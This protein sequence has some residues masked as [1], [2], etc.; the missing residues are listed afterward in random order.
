MMKKI[1]IFVLLA[2]VL[3]LAPAHMLMAK[4][5]DLQAIKKAVKKNPNIDPD[6]EVKWFKI[7][8]T[9]TWT[10]KDKVKITLPVS[11]IELILEAEHDHHFRIDRDEYDL[12]IREIFRELKKVGP[13]AFIEIC[14]DGE[15]IKIWF[16]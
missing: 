13:M 3:S 9:D 8:I 10:K 1:T 2:F 5:S 7:L 12:D 11:L 4:D 14:E 15:L 6:Q 16:E